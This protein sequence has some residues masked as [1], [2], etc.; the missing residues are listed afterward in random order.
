MLL[1]VLVF[2]VGAWV[3]FAPL[4]T[5]SLHS[6]PDPIAN[7]QAAVTAIES[8][9][10]RE[11][12]LDVNPV[13]QTGLLS[14]GQQTEK[15]IVYIHGFT[16]CPAQF[17]Q[18]GQE[19]YDQGYNVFVPR[20]PHHG[21]S[22]R[23]TTDLSRLT[24]EELAD[25]ADESMDI[26]Q[27]LGEEVTAVGLSG[28]GSVAGWIAQEREDADNVVIIAPM[29]GILSLPPFTVK[30]VA[31]A[32]LT[33]PDIFVWWDPA[34]KEAIPGP[35]Y[36]YPRYATEAV[37]NLLRLGRYVAEEAVGVLPAAG[38][39]VAVTNAIDPAV[40]NEVFAEIVDRWR[41]AGFPVE[42]FEFPAELNLL[43]DVVDPRQPEAQTE[44]VYPTLIDLITA[45]KENS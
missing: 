42:S 15:V 16:N 25:F 11:E 31:N 3:W 6:D 4:A 37:G 14:H 28:G 20:M 39:I 23:L 34:T 30:P 19:F 22:D 2:V 5:G 29:F 41:V 43:H 10:E 13:C 44:L 36:A 18:L 1:V 7:Y 40:N 38:R 32:A 24:A 26:A 17:D 21:L 45:E 35:D 27:G 9:Q 33:L 8:W 12:Q